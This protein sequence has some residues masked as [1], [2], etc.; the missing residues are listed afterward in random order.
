[1][2][3]LEGVAKVEAARGQTEAA[4]RDYQQVVDRL[5]QPAYVIEFGDY[6]ASLG[7]TKQAQQE[8]GLVLTEEKIF[9]SQ[10]VNVDLELS[11]F[12]A[13][14][15]DPKGAL[16]SASA[17]YA[18]RHSTLVEDAYAWALH[19]NGNDAMRFPTPT[20]R[21]ASAPRARSSTTTGARSKLRSA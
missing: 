5:P 7:R 3:P 6:L 2:P 9:Q 1:M 21:F 19:V 14:H 13:D 4:I 15:G 10:G 12:Q 8:Y 18:R 16:T 11:L 20:R 17:E